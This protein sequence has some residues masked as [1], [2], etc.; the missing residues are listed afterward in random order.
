MSMVIPFL[1][2]AVRLNGEKAKVLHG[3]RLISS[4]ARQRLWRSL[5]HRDAPAATD[6]ALVPEVFIANVRG[7][8]KSVHH[9]PFLVRDVEVVMQ[10]NVRHWR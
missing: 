4:V 10:R 8:D 9:E 6:L 2:T 3:A 5:A 7:G 1:W